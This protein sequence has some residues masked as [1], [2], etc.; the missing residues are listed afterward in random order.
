MSHRR[1]VRQ[2]VLL[3]AFLVVYGNAKSALVGDA[4]E[5][6]PLGV[7]FGLLLT[8]L[9]ALWARY[10]L[11]LDRDELGLANARARQSL[12]WGLIVTLVVL[13]LTQL[14]AR[15]APAGSLADSVPRSLL[16][17]SDEQVL[18]RIGFM[19]PFD[20]ALPEEVAFRGVLLA[21]LRRRYTAVPAV[22]LAAIPFA[23]WHVVLT[24]LE[25]ERR[26]PLLLIG[27]LGADFTGGLWFG[28]LRVR[29][30]HLAGGVL[31]HWLIDAGLMLGA[32]ANQTG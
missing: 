11:R 15:L 27:K 10:V 2:A 30:G 24:G 19:L 12:I 9:M 21:A 17:L 23:L 3:S 5:G 1:D 29:T 18:R 8:G 13:A 4:P 32:R 6:V 16:R 7:G 22:V 25:T 14:G 20:T 31:A 26:D 28:F